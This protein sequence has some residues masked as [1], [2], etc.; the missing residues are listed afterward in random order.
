MLPQQK[1]SES[2]GNKPPHAPLAF[3]P[4]TAARAV[5]PKA[6]NNAVNRKPPVAPAAY[7]PQPVPRVLQAKRS[8]AQSLQASKAFAGRPISRPGS[9]VQRMEEQGPEVNFSDDESPKVDYRHCCSYNTIKGEDAWNNEDAITNHCLTYCGTK[10]KVI[11]VKFAYVVGAPPPE[12]GHGSELA[13]PA[14]KGNKSKGKGG[15]QKQGSAK[16]EKRWEAFQKS[17]GR[18][19][20]I[21]YQHLKGNTDYQ[22]AEKAVKEYDGPTPKWW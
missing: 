1:T 19:I 4:N 8:P 12:L 11:L 13:T 9:V 3:R 21:G 7:R 14:P 6:A 22:K 16:D 17:M 20:A 18:I 15:G 5:Q 2:A 10:E